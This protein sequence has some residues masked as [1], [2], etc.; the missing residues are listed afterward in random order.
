M[1]LD[2]LTWLEESREHSRTF[3]YRPEVLGPIKAAADGLAEAVPR[4]DLS[5]EYLQHAGAFARV[6]AAE[7]GFRLAEVWRLTLASDR[8]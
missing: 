7:A 5:D 2:P 8:P 3:V 1:Y 6:R 4:I